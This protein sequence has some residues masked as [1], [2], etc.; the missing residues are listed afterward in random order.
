M[1][2]ARDDAPEETR[3]NEVLRAL[4]LLDE[5][6][7][8]MQALNVDL[9]DE[10]V[11]EQEAQLLREYVETERTPIP[12]A[13]FVL[14]L[15]QM[16]VFAVYEL[17][18]TW[19]QRAQEIVKWA[20]TLEALDGDERQAA[21]AQ[22]RR[23]IE[24]RASEARDAEARSLVF[25]RADDARFVEEL[26]L[27]VNRTE[28]VFR[29][30]EAV[31]LTLAKHEVP[32]RAGVYAAAPGYARVDLSNGSMRWQ[33]ELG[34]NEIEV[35]SR[36]GLG[37]ALRA[38]AKQNEQILPA[39]MQEKVATLEREGYGLNRVVAVLDDG[40]EV[41]GVRVLWNTE[42]VAVDG[43]ERIPFDVAS[44]VDVRPDPTPEREPD[45]TEPF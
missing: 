42:V 39:A 3:L 32:R 36:R 21:V 6:F 29:A 26:R 1:T 34:R 25:E 2:E 18:R 40:T 45:E 4:P 20:K 23:E 31:R 11:Q 16:W 28:L 10:Y 37:D 30:V 15:S 17:L 14:A 5:L 27:A 9:V 24:R 12:A 33:L 41:P 38:L 13:L 44:V 35:V 22:K 7:L 8:G 19:R 43:H